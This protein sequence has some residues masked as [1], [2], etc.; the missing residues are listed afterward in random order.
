MKRGRIPEAIG[1]G[2]NGDR[3]VY[4]SCHG[5]GEPRGAYAILKFWYR[6]AS[7]RAP[8]PS[9]TDMETFRGGYR[10]SIRGRSLPLATHVDPAEVNDKIPLEA[11]VESV[12]GRLRPHSKGGH[13]H[14]H[15]DH[16]EQW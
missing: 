5:R 4:G 16:F 8:N 13:T 1:G 2:S 6:N 10:L 15:A 9:R 14:I 12:I 11:E 3:G 7:V